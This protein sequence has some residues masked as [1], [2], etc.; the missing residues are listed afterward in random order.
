MKTRNMLHARKITINRAEGLTHECGSVDFTGPACWEMAELH[1]VVAARTAPRE[2]S[3]H[4]CDAII[5]W[6]APDP[7][8][9]E[10]RYD[11]YHPNTGKFQT[12][13]QHLRS[14]WNFY[15]GRVLPSHI[16]RERWQAF[17]NECRV[18]VASWTKLLD[19]CHI[20]GGNEPV[21][22]L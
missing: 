5:V 1:L 2:I 8:V 14:V 16:S 18:D 17:V 22:T 11:L 12:L 3:Y 19:T 7:I 10:A 15:S 13:A 4:K 9:Y 6:D 21:V 20:P